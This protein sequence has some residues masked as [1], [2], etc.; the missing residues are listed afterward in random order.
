MTA[1]CG[2]VHTATGSCF[3][4]DEHLFALQ[5][6]M[7]SKGVRSNLSLRDLLSHQT[8]TVLDADYSVDAQ[9]IY[10]LPTMVSTANN[11]IFSQCSYINTS[12]STATYGETSNQEECF[13]RLMN[14][15]RHR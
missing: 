3:T 5:P 6:R 11:Q 15:H 13:V 8:T 10:P 7:H 2:V 9:L 1:P 12:G 14:L 4:T